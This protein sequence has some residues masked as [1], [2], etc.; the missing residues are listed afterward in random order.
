MKLK[1]LSLA[2]L[3]KK[4]AEEQKRGRVNVDVLKA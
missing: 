1:D 2:D 3:A 4:Y